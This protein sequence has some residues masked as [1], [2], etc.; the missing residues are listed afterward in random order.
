M[1]AWYSSNL[2][3]I[4]DIFINL[5]LALSIQLPLSSGVF[6]VAGL[7]F[8]TVGEYTTAILVLHKVVP[9][10][11]AILMGVALS[12]VGSFALSL[13]LYRV[14]GLYLAMVT[15]A[16]VL[17]IGV[18][19]TNGGTFTGGASGLVGVPLDVNTADMLFVALVA[20]AI[21]VAME[22]GRNGR[23]A[24]AMR[25]DPVLAGSL[26]I[27]VSRSRTYVILLS[28]AFGAA[29]G[30]LNVLNSGTVNPTDAGFAL[31]TTVLTMVIVGGRRSWL[32]AAI[33]VILLTWL[34]AAL[35]FF[36]PWQDDIAFGALVIIACTVA[37]DGLLGVGI[38]IS[39][40]LLKLL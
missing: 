8:F 33:G 28:G 34:P 31:V 1:T 15:V 36:G 17:L 27:S 25:A 12:V 14:R 21:C 20:I 30:G 6:S 40:W 3:I 37:P 39:R 4:Q 22:R 11:V 5:V 23:A 19:A 38:G 7:G 35:Q 2:T 24:T 18:V 13:L 9:A 16:F 29:A 10:D 32:G 26:G